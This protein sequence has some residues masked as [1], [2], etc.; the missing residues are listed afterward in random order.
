[1]AT[2]GS[3]LSGHTL[4]KGSR[5]LHCLW[6]P[7]FVLAIVGASLVHVNS[8]VSSVETNFMFD[9]IASEGLQACGCCKG[10]PCSCSGVPLER[11]TSHNFSALG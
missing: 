1:M 10:L 11:W 6:C 5:L 3:G 9:R 2:V 7:A 4:V 8:L